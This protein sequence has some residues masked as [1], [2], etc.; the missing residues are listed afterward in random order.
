MRRVNPLFAHLNPVD[1]DISSLIFEGLFAANEYGEIV[2]RLAERLVISSDG[3]EYVVKLRE[4]I[5]WQNDVPFNA[6]DVIYTMS[7]LSEPDYA[8]ISPIGEVLGHGRGPE[9]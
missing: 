6:D 7:L 8:R 3:I 4:D 5:R 9:T 2:P 1:R